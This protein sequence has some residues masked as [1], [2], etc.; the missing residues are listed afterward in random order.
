M[1]RKVFQVILSSVDVKELLQNE[2]SADK[3]GRALGQVKAIIEEYGAA[4]YNIGMI[5]F[6][7]GS[8][9][10][11]LGCAIGFLVH[12]RNVNKR[13]E[14]KDGSLWTIFGIIFG[15]AAVGILILAQT[16]GQSLFL[17]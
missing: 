1:V 14:Q 16:V 8:F 5:I 7:Y 3:E 15:F 11:L 9:L 13:V 2:N 6:I 4:G 17:N 12:G 10:A